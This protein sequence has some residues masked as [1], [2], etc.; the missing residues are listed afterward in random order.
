VAGC[1]DSP[2]GQYYVDPALGVDDTTTTGN[3]NC[4]FRTLSHAIAAASMM[5]LAETIL[6]V[7][8][9]AAPT[10]GAA[11]GEKFPIQVPPQITIRSTNTQANVPVL[12]VPAGQ[13][14]IVADDS[15][16]T[17][18]NLIVDGQN[19]QATTGIA[20][21]GGSDSGQFEAGTP[22][23]NPS[24]LDHVT[25]KNTLGPAMVVGSAPGQK[26]SPGMVTLN[27]GV[28][29]TGSGTQASPAS[30]LSASALATVTINGGRGVDH[31]S[32]GANT[33]YGILIT[34]GASI[35]LSGSIDAQTPDNNDIDADG[36]SVAGAWIAQDA[37]IQG[38]NLNTVTGLHASK[39]QVGVHVT[40]G[41]FLQL[42]SSY[43]GNNTQAGIAVATVGAAV[44]DLSTIDLGTRIGSNFGQNVLLAPGSSATALCLQVGSSVRTLVAA[45]NIFGNI[46]CSQ[47]AGTL[48]RSANCN[49]NADI[50]GL[51]PSDLATV[52][53]SL[54]K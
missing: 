36:N 44:D 8:D 22:D 23:N 27:A 12:L 49:G 31:T 11:T 47:D 10:L 19:H 13:V 33:Q 34:G 51:N 40:A 5:N 17:L 26:A 42:R 54:C 28:V 1:T 7:N 53:V 43:L 45:G 20:I 52:D 35:S 9:V 39:N 50:G 41:S 14:G 48:R 16:L 4:P 2:N 38:L 30:G 18:S 3:S 46:D 29:L 21:Y 37:T 32:F 6:I 24:I 25:I 15:G